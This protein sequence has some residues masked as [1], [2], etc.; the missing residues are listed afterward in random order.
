[1]NVLSKY[2]CREC[3]FLVKDQFLQLLARPDMLQLFVLSMGPQF[4]KK[5]INSEA[6]I[7]LII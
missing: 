3:A 7:E 6:T 5:M 2:M 1:V 4:L